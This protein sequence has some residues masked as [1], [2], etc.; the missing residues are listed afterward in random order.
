MCVAVLPW[1]RLLAD[2]GDL[3]HEILF[4]VRGEGLVFDSMFLNHHPVSVRNI[5]SVSA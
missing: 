3:L 4:L 2:R 5:L 1:F